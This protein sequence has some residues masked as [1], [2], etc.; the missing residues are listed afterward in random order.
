MICLTLLK[1]VQDAPIA[2]E[3]VRRAV[4]SIH[5]RAEGVRVP[6]TVTIGVTIERGES[7]E[8]MIKRAD[9]ALYKSKNNGRNRV[10]SEA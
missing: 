4:E 7:L 9:D 8:Q 2:F 10:T 3:R 1:R 5:L 6:L